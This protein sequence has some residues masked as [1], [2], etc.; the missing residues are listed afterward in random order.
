MPAM[1]DVDIQQHSKAWRQ[2]S[3]IPNLSAGKGK[4]G[5]KGPTSSLKY[6]PMEI[7]LWSC[8]LES[9]NALTFVESHLIALQVNS[10]S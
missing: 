5:R 7:S 10:I 3:T 4:D 6:T 2:I 9:P 1:L 8:V